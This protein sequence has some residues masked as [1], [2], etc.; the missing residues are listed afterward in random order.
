M[1]NLG[2]GPLRIDGV[3]LDLLESQR[4]ALN[5]LLL[6]SPTL[7]V[8]LTRREYEAI[9]GIANMLDTWADATYFARK[10]AR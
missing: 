2:E 9:E 10:E 1:K 3:D 6:R 8:T 7:T 4:K 5:A